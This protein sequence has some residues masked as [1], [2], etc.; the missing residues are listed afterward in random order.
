MRPDPKPSPPA[1][2]SPPTAGS[3]TTRSTT[4]GSVTLRHNSRLHH[5]GLGARLAGTPV[6][7]LID[8]LHIRVIHRHTGELIRELILDPTRDYQPRGLPPGPPKTDRSHTP[9][10]IPIAGPPAPPQPASRLAAGHPQ[11][12]GLDPGEDGAT[13]QAGMPNNP[14]K[15]NDVPRHLLTV[16]RDITRSRL[17]ES[18]PRP[19][20]YERN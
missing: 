6:T 16:S 17:G 1:R 8:N 20:H 2:S 5:I 15:C 7:L 4:G 19:T 3:G 9:A 11:G 14:P 13:L 10:G 12:P 18:N